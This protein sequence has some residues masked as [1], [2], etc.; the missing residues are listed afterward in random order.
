M[1][2][3]LRWT[4][5]FLSFCFFIIF[6]VAAT[7]H[8]TVIYLYYQSKGQLSVLW[9]RES[10]G[11]FVQ[12]NKLSIQVQENI[13]LAD[14]IKKF[15]VDSLGYLK[16]NNF[17]K[18]FNQKSNTTL[19]V[20]TASGAY[21]LKP[22][23]WK[24]PFVG[25]VTYKGFFEKTLAIKEYIQLTAEGYDADLRSV[26]AWST[27]GWFDDPLLSSNLLRS[28]G[29]LCN[30]LFHELFHATYYSANK[31][32]FNE[33]IANFIA[34][35]ATLQFLKNDS[36]ELKKYKASYSDNLLFNS[37]MLRQ[38]NHLK[39]LYKRIENN[40][41]KQ[42]L[43]QLAIT[44]IADSLNDLPFINPKKYLAR[45]ED[46]MKFKNA[47]FV[48]FQQYDSMQDTLEKVFNKIYS[49]NLKNMVRDLRLNRINY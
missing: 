20:I 32:D 8:K 38:A 47:Y 42:S 21:D 34:H 14:E 19:W 22:Y 10:I 11:D 49:A 36:V 4:R 31:V 2:V 16:T 6:V 44:K 12:S 33:N 46:I 9:N 7:N 35:K 43:K 39:S 24:F 45:S 15:S 29:S 23:V 18:I 1:T 40:P 28:K 27:L 48:D 17:T 5:F 13:L 37:Y 30:L 25:N 3:I 41:K 26:S